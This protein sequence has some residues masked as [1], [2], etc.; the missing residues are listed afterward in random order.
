[1][2]W[3]QATVIS[4]GDERAVTL[5]PGDAKYGRCFLATPVPEISRRIVGVH[6][7]NK[8]GQSV[9]FVLCN[10]K[11]EVETVSGGETKT[12][13]REKTT[14]PAT[15]KTRA[16]RTSFTL[17]GGDTLRLSMIL[18]GDDEWHPLPPNMSFT[19]RIEGLVECS[20][21]SGGS[22]MEEQEARR[23][24]ICEE[25]ADFV[26]D[27]EDVTTSMDRQIINGVV[28]HLARGVPNP[29]VLQDAPEEEADQNYEPVMRVLAEET[30]RSAM[31]L[32]GNRNIESSF[33]GVS[34]AV[35]RQ[36]EELQAAPDAST[37]QE[38]LKAREERRQK[39]ARIFKK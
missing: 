29:D 39:L 37:L 35:K 2:L 7:T 10:P 25:M 9:T 27:A 28:R 12:F 26:D 16:A 36:A 1:M 11:Y 19:L 20:T 24:R 14:D 38:T 22:S 4:D 21:D 18:G 13:R 6:S 15:G 23:E 31:L 8:R 5:R 17:R 32:G 3:L 33:E 30:A 34:E